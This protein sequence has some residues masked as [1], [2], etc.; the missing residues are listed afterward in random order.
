MSTG[1]P[2]LASR[3]GGNTTV[4]QDTH[5][6]T[7]Y[8]NIDDCVNKLNEFLKLSEKEKSAARKKIKQAYEQN[9]TLDVFAQ[10]YANMI[11][12]VINS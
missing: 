6:I 3:G 11:K 4:E 9:Y 12:Q 2:V 5:A 1:T 10:N 8:D 7:L